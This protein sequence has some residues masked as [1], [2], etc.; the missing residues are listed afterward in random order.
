[1]TRK[2]EA[3]TFNELA[4]IYDKATGRCARIQPIEKITDWAVKSKLIRYDRKQDLFFRKG[5]KG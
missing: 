1:M 2:D 3:L 5:R 4:D